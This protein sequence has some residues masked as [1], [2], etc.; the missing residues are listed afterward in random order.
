MAISY[1]GGVSGTLTA[2]TGSVSLSGTL[3]GGSNSS[4]SAG[5]LVVVYFGGGG[6]TNFSASLACSGNNNGTYTALTGQ[7]A[8]DTFDTN[9]RA[10]YDIQGATVDTQ[11]N[12]SGLTYSTAYGNA[13]SVM[14]FRGV[15]PAVPLSGVTPVY[16]TI[17]NAS[18][19]SF[20]A[21]TPTVAGSW[22]VFGG[23]NCQ[24][25]TGAAITLPS[26]TNSVVRNVD[27]TTS[28]F[29]SAVGVYTSWTS[30]AYT[31]TTATGG[32]TSTSC[33]AARIEFVIK[34]AVDH[35]TTGD[36]AGSGSEVVG[37]ADRQS[38]AVAHT[39]TGALTGQIGSVGGSV[40]R[41]RAFS[42]TGVLPGQT[43]TITGSADREA[44]SIPHVAT[45]VLLGQEG[46]V[47][48]S[49]ARTRVHTTDGTLSGGA[50][51]ITGDAD[52][53]VLV[54]PHVASGVLVGQGSAVAGAAFVSHLHATAGVLVG[55]GSEVVGDAEL[56][57]PV[58]HETS[59]EL[60]GDGA[61]VAGA[62][63]H[64]AYDLTITRE[65]ATQLYQIYLLHG[66]TVGSPLV[67]TPTTRSA[68]GLT[69]SVT[70]TGGTVSIATTAN[71]TVGLPPL[72]QMIEELAALHGLGETLSVTATSRTA[73]AISQ[74]IATT[75]GVTTV[76]R[77]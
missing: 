35:T 50:A 55:P 44:A 41:F 22:I 37:S 76:T 61:E 3:T 26:A 77:V 14:V 20:A 59:G 46:M 11:I 58:E 32:A 43:A 31:P 72:A 40:E 10:F 63:D 36:L 30:G 53:E 70:E 13:V 47:V 64:Q 65:V 38:A 62:A 23:G 75:G 25:T 17:T 16:G 71:T 49:A 73:G 27:G 24:G 28:D 57:S 52:H 19:L 42:T 2:S 21:I 60:I 33:S 48:G 15:N 29:C 34:P 9:V 66:L 45:G 12:L 56:I 74:T 69:Q 4:P 51:T 7:Y 6:T 54:V 68:G 1:V 5:D 8:N 18:T 39:S 67:V